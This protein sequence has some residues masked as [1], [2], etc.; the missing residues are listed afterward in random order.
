[1]TQWHPQQWHL[2]PMVTVAMGVVVVNCAAAVDAAATIPL[3]VLMVAAKTPSLPPPWTA[4][5]INNNCYCCNRQ[6]LSLLL[7]YS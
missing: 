5:S 1:M 6:P 3:S 4:A 7:P 2:W